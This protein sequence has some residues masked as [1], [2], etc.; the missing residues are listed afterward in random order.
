MFLVGTTYFVAGSY[1]ESALLVDIDGGEEAIDEHYARSP[2]Y[3][4]VTGDGAMD[5]ST[6]APRNLQ[7]HDH[8][9]TELPGGEGEK[10]LGYV[11]F[12]PAR[13]GFFANEAPPAAKAADGVGGGGSTSIRRGITSSMGMRSQGH[14][15]SSNSSSHGSNAPLLKEVIDRENDAL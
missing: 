15:G 1:P 13:T 11:D 7:P 12:H 9:Y 5:Y 3:A 14:G 8:P 2:V 10:P 6:H 4:R